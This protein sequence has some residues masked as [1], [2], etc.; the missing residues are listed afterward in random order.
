MY[1]KQTWKTGDLI[2]EG[3]LNHMEDGIANAS[4][5]GDGSFVI[6]MVDDHGKTD[7]TWKEIHDALASGKYVTVYESYRENANAV[8]IVCGTNVRREF[9]STT[10]EY[11]VFYSFFEY[12]DGLTMKILVTISED[13]YLYPDNY[14]PDNN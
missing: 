3:K 10:D 9:G 11:V 7:K 6:H 1:E 8:G 2:T 14:Y 12:P 5:S 4:G 13:G